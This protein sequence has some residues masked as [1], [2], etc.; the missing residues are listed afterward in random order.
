M[1]A[2]EAAPS[3]F[4]AWALDYRFTQRSAHLAGHLDSI[5]LLLERAQYPSAFSLVRTAFEHALLD[6][7]L[8]TAT[9]RRV[10]HDNVDAHEEQRLRA[11]MAGDVPGFSGI[12]KVTRYGKAIEIEREAQRLMDATGR[13]TSASLASR[14]GEFGHST[15]SMVRPVHPRQSDTSR[16]SGRSRRPDDHADGCKPS[17]H[18]P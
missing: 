6:R 18:T 1:A 14:P 3:R 15:I 13:L 11:M 2:L 9:K 16:R 7:L 5:G 4:G 12:Y 8:L 17:C 10:R